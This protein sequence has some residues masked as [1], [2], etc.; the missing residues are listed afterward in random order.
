MFALLDVLTGWLLFLSLAVVMGVVVTRWVVLPRAVPPAPSGLDGSRETVARLGGWAAAVLLV[1]LA[2]VFVRQ[3]VEFHDPFEPWMAAARLLL[4][5]TDWARTWLMAVGAALVAAAGFRVA[6]QGGVGGW[7]AATA[8]VLVLGAFPA[9]TGHANTGDL[10]ELT[11]AADVLPVWAAGGWIGTL[12][13]VLALEWRQRRTGGSNA[14]SVLPVLVPR[15]SPVAIACVA[16]LMATGVLAAWIHLESLGA[17][18]GTR[19][20]RLLLLKVALV[21]GVL[22]LGALNWRRL[23]PLLEESLGQDAMRRAATIEL[24]VANVVLAVTAV[25]V[26]TSPT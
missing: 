21:L 3:L 14:A 24:V 7:A 4:G 11:L 2:L 17:L 20:G 10:R 6:R 23:T 8:G 25:L 15:F 9:L 12:C 13:V 19:Y 18:V 5:S 16:T 1:S 26:R 22:A